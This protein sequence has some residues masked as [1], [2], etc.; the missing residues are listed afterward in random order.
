MSQGVPGDAR[1]NNTGA[2]GRGHQLL[3]AV[4][5]LEEDEKVHSSHLVDVFKHLA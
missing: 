2:Q 5:E 3:G 1:Q 4:R